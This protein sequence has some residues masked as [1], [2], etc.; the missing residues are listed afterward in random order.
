MNEKTVNKVWR[1]GLCVV[2]ALTAAG[3]AATCAK[4]NDKQDATTRKLGHG[5]YVR[6]LLSDTTGKAGT[7]EKSAKAGLSTKEFLKISGATIELAEDAEIE[8][9]VNFYSANKT[10][11][12]V[13]DYDEDTGFSASSLPQG[14]S[15]AVYM[16]IEII[17]IS[18]NDGVVSLFEM[19]G[20]IDQLEVVVAK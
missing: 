9:Q 7:E 2:A 10:F 15:S 16:K 18:D 5:D 8:Y 19:G 11:L 1:I 12:A 3:F 17:P 6:Y 20:Y 14:A 13:A 4:L